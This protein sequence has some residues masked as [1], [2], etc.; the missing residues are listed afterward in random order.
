MSTGLHHKSKQFFKT[1]VP[2]GV[3]QS[4]LHKRV[5]MQF[6]EKIGLV[7]FGYV[8]QRDDEHRLV[9]GLTVSARH[10]DNHYCIGSYE[11]YDI[12]LVERR[13]TLHF[14]GKAPQAHDWIIMVF[15][16]HTT[17]DLPHIFL[18]RRN[19]DETFYA[20]LF[21]KFSNLTAIPTSVF[22]Q[23]NRQFI[24]KYALYTEPA[25]MVAVG[26]L[27]TPEITQV[28]AEAFGTL[29]VEIADKCVYVYAEH[30]HPTT[31][32]LERMLR[33]GLW[34]AQTIDQAVSHT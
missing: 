8:D 16:L 33:A 24:E 27:F 15:D 17:K 13:D 23:H 26:Q 21:T 14:P 22:S 29:T 32:L 5:F 2:A 11:N 12:T 3:I 31:H 9:R 7:Y 19:H 28:I 1:L 20:H 10:R 4:R 18:G 34:L 25:H 6:A 30:G